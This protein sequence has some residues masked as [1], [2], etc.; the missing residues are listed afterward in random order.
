MIELFDKVKNS[1]YELIIG[2]IFGVI[3]VLVVTVPWAIKQD[4]ISNLRLQVEIYKLLNTHD[5][6]IVD[7]LN[8]T[9]KLT[10]KVEALNEEL[11][12]KNNEILKLRESLIAKNLEIKQLKVIKEKLDH[13]QSNTN[14]LLDEFQNYKNISNGSVEI[15]NHKNESS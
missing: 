3:A 6:A 4:E 10:R 15:E 8:N 14:L 5:E 13:I 11:S 7:K 9:D 12:I 1:K 2:T